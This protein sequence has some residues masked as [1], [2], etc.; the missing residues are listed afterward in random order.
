MK[1]A[2]IKGLNNEQGMT[3]LELTVALGLFGIIAVISLNLMYY[4]SRSSRI[5]EDKVEIINNMNHALSIISRAIREVENPKG[6]KI[7]SVPGTSDFKIL[8]LP[9]NINFQVN[10]GAIQMT[11]AAGTQPLMTTDKMQATK[12]TFSKD[13]NNV[14]EINLVVQSRDGQT[15]ESRLKAAVRAD[16]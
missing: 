16:I 13:D 15:V 14:I 8:I 12:L 6:I 11:N 4:S 5:I 10:N 9:G 7:E 3:L 2:R 1:K